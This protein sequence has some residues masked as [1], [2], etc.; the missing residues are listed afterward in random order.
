MHHLRGLIRGASKTSIKHFESIAVPPSAHSW[1]ECWKQIQ[2]VDMH[3]R[4]AKARLLCTPTLL[5]LLEDLPAEERISVVQQACEFS[6]ASPPL[7]W[8]GVKDGEVVYVKGDVK[9]TKDEIGQRQSILLFRL[10]GKANACSAERVASAARELLEMGGDTTSCDSGPAQ[11]IVCAVARFHG[12]VQELADRDPKAALVLGMNEKMNKALGGVGKYLS[13]IVDISSRDAVFTFLQST[14]SLDRSIPASQTGA[15]QLAVRIKKHLENDGNCSV[16]EPNACSTFSSDELV[17][18]CQKFDVDPGSVYTR[19][20]RKIQEWS[21]A[22][23]SWN[24]HSVERKNA[25]LSV[26]KQRRLLPRRLCLSS[27]SAWCGHDLEREWIEHSIGQVTERGE[28]SS[29]SPKPFTNAIATEIARRAAVGFVLKDPLRNLVG[30]RLLHHYSYFLA[31]GDITPHHSSFS[32]FLDE[33][34]DCHSE[35]ERPDQLQFT[36]RPP[37]QTQ[38]IRDALRALAPRSSYWTALLDHHS[39]AVSVFTAPANELR[40]GVTLPTEHQCAPAARLLL[41]KGAITLP[42]VLYEDADIIV[43]NKPSGMATTRHALSQ[44]QSGDKE[45][46]D[47]VSLILHRFPSM[48]SLPRNGIVHRL[49]TETSGCIAVA[50]TLPGATALRHQ[51]GTSGVFSTFNKVY[52]ALCVVLSDNLKDIPL[53]GRLSD[54]MDLKVVTNY[55]ITHFFSQS[56]VAVVECRIQ[57]GKKHQIRRHLAA[58]GLPVLGDVVHGGAACAQAIIPRTALHAS[59]V[60]ICHPRP[61]GATPGE[62]M[63]LVAPLP[64]DFRVALHKL[65]RSERR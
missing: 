41:D 47:L 12:L 63:V 25:I 48:L 44:S 59:A 34:G 3:G 2:L 58:A 43:F 35:R 50:K 1:K 24:S 5:K 22:F 26:V 20:A 56:R 60:Q 18:I 15:T 53:S 27:L 57:Q 11:V 7:D 10:L 65:H 46:I 54:P 64:H 45:M 17:S 29:S 16:N 33:C 38:T 9:E 21:T 13:N 55:R 6:M 52:I 61:Q 62:G 49:D 8:D 40:V 14:A 32:S 23:Y 19:D 30:N 4:T 39:C 37:S 51:F 31:R 42:P 36:M 28:D